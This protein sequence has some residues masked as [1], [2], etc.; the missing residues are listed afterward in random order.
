MVRAPDRYKDKPGRSDSPAGLAGC[1][2][3]K[4]ECTKVLFPD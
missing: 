2:A 1:I 4:E 3:R